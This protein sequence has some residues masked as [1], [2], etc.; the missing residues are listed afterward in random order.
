MDIVKMLMWACGELNRCTINP[1]ENEA[2]VRY[3]LDKYKFL[4]LSAQVS[5][6][7]LG[8]LSSFIAKEI[9]MFGSNTLCS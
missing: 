5:I 6:T 3:A 1:G 4:S 8:F 9:F 7:V 2:V